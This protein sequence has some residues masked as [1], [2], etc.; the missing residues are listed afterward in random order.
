MTQPPSSSEAQ[1]ELSI[2]LAGCGGDDPRRL[3]VV[4][5]LR[6]AAQ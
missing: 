3:P 4:S 1:S 5:T 2:D 6:L